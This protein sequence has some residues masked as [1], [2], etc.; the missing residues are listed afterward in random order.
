MRTDIIMNTAS[1]V[2]AAIAPWQ[3]SPSPARMMPCSAMTAIAMS[4]HP[5]V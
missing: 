1:A 3:M 4:S 2:S 5:S